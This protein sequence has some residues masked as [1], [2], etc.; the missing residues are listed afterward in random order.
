MK[1]PQRKQWAIDKAKEIY[2]ERG[3]TDMIS[4][5]DLAEAVKRKRIK[6]QERIDAYKISMRG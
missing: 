6:T 2:T 5:F 1:K 4:I 3:D